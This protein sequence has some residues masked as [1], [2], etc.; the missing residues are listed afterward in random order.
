MAIFA[1]VRWDKINTHHVQNLH[2]V[3]SSSTG[4]SHG[5]EG[6]PLVV[7]NTLY[8][9]TPYPN[10]LIALDLSHKW[11]LSLVRGRQS[12][13]LHHHGPFRGLPYQAA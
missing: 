8:I 10:N 11:I 5:H 3:T 9:V 7:N 2:M 1:S 12:L 6:Q 4:I 13:G